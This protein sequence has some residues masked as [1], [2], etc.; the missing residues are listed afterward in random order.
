MVELL[1]IDHIC[2]YSIST[3][4][5]T[6]VI[7]SAEKCR[8]YAHFCGVLSDFGFLELVVG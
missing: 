7:Q 5:E 1:K 3:R 2:M 4:G 8:S 6:L